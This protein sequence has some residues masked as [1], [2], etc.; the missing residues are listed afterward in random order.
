M[1]KILAIALIIIMMIFVVACRPSQSVEGNVATAMPTNT[2]STTQEPTNAV[3]PTATADSTATANPTASVTATATAKPGTTNTPTATAKPGVTSTPKPTATVKPTATPKATTK[4]TATPKPTAAP[5]TKPT[6]TPSGG[7]SSCSHIYSGWI[8]IKYPTTTEEGQ[9]KNSCMYCGHTLYQSVPK[10]E[11]KYASVPD[12]ILVQELPLLTVY[13]NN[14]C[15]LR[16]CRTWGDIPEIIVLADESMV[17]SYY[18]KNNEKI[19][20]T[21]NP[22]SYGITIGSIE[23]DGTYSCYIQTGLS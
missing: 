20:F 18:N 1:K 17:V 22:S 23:E 10:K 16:D 13:K 3:T 2:V 12:S 21:L 19:S 6:P 11:D 4:P 7:S 9:Q 5:T 8:T 14:S 15:R